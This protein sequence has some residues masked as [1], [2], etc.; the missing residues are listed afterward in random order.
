MFSWLEDLTEVSSRTLEPATENSLASF[1]SSSGLW[2]HFAVLLN[3]NALGD[4]TWNL[5]TGFGEY[6]VSTCSKASL[7]AL[8]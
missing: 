8:K 3:G 2:V 6:V 7:N 5:G 4:L 1:T